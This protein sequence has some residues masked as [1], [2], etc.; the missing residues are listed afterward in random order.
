MNVVV[1]P[2]LL[3]IEISRFNVVFN[4]LPDRNAAL[5]ALRVAVAAGA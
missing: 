2:L 1:W 3:V 4:V 5:A